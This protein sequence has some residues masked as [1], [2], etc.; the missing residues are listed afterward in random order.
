MTSPPKRTPLVVIGV[1][2]PDRAD[3]GIGPLV[4]ARL[5]TLPG[6][7]VISRSS[8]AFTI[9][10]EWT[11]AEAAV[12]I[13]AASVIST[14]GRIHR[15]DLS[16]DKLPCELG[17]SSTHAFGL[18]EAIALARVLNRMPKSVVVYAVEGVCFDVG[19]AMTTEVAAAV[20][21]VVGLVAAEI[22]S[23]CSNGKSR[24]KDERS[25]C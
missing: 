22:A 17:L 21:E 10:E 12:L 25:R 5:G 14:P 3:D 24:K 8:D 1:G 9:I 15:I 11:G 23:H 2:N 18:A 16:V 19:A 4:A 7:R 6:V 13:D 20:D